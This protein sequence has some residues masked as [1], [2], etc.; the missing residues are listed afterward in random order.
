MF[1]GGA[2]M[3]AALWVAESDAIETTLL[4]VCGEL[5]IEASEVAAEDPELTSTLE[6]EPVSAK[7]VN[8]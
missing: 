3:L 4:I 2:D 8:A 7:L 6:I 5:L 1:E